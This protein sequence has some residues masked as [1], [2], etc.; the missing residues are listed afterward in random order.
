MVAV[1][2]PS[3]ALP[4][5]CRMGAAAA[6]VVAVTASG[7]GPE[8]ELSWRE[9]ELPLSVAVVGEAVDGAGA[10]ASACPLY[11]PYPA[12]RPRAPAAAADQ[13]PGPARAGVDAAA[14][15]P[16]DME[17]W[18]CVGVRRV[19]WADLLCS[20]Q[21][22]KQVRWQLA[23]PAAR[24]TALAAPVIMCLRADAIVPDATGL[25]SR[26]ICPPASVNS[27]VD[28]CKAGTGQATVWI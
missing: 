1:T 21:T 25:N 16:V 2:E 11:R 17:S 23:G 13:D 8:V 5:L 4:V 14:A 18:C 22:V 27:L 24:E 6:A 15:G 3:L 7:V 28:S 26:C 20:W 10:S 12:R 19:A 9:A